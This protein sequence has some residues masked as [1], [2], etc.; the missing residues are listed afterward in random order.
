MFS[1]VLTL[2]SLEGPPECCANGLAQFLLFSGDRKSDQGDDGSGSVTVSAHERSTTS[3]FALE[4]TNT[5]HDS[6]LQRLRLQIVPQG[7]AAPRFSL[8]VQLPEKPTLPAALRVQCLFPRQWFVVCF[9]R[10]HSRAIFHSV[11]IALTTKCARMES[12]FLLRLE[13][14]YLFWSEC[15]R[16]FGP[17]GEWDIENCT[18]VG[19][20]PWKLFCHFKI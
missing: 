11:Q 10:P 1:C 17:H 6:T 19:W 16:A 4:E 9:Q 15:A 18:V 12:H 14:K 3:V 2:L 13:A 5:C 7:W 8:S 20:K